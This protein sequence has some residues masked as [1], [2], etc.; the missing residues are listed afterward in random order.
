MP[1]IQSEVN[2]ADPSVPRWLATLSDHYASVSTVRWSHGGSFL[3][4]ASDDH[5]ALLYDLSSAPAPAVFGSKEPPN[6]ENWRVKL[7]LRGHT[8]EIVSDDGMEMG[9]TD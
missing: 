3:A 8:S 7:T 9:V 6:V 2:E 4:S 5:T 1:P